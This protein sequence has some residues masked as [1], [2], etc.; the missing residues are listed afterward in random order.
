M[1]AAI[2]SFRPAPDEAAWDL[3]VFRKTRERFCS[4]Q[5]KQH[6][7]SSLRLALSRQEEDG[8]LNC[9]IRA[10]ELECALSDLGS[11]EAQ[12]AAE[13]LDALAAQALHP[14]CTEP[15]RD[16]LAAFSGL[17]LPPFVFVSHVEGFSYYG[18]HPLDFW[19]LAGVLKLRA[20]SAAVIG[21]R[22]IGSTLSSIVRR[23]LHCRGQR[24]ERI[25]VRPTGAP[26]HRRLELTAEQMR[27]V[28][29][30]LR[31]G[32]EFMVVDEGPGFSGS[33]FTA[34]GRALR[35]AGVPNQ[36][37]Q[38]L[39]SRSPESSELQAR[40][41]PEWQS[42]RFCSVVQG[43][44]IP[45]AGKVYC[46]GGYW[47]QTRF[48][49][50]REWPACWTQLERNKYF[51]ADG[52][53]LFKFEGFGRYG[54]SVAE[55]G[56]QLAEAGFAP[57]LLGSDN[58]FVEYAAAPGRPMRA[59]QCRM[60]TLERL[61]DYC[62]FRALNQTAA[63]PGAISLESMLQHNLKVEFGRERWGLKAPV[64]RL[65]V[66]DG[67]MMPH[68]WI[69]ADGQLMK[70]DGA[71]HGDDHL[72]PGATDIA[73][74]LAGAIAEW[75]LGREQ[76]DFFLAEYR[77]RSGDD[78]ASR[79]PFYLLAYSVFRMAYCRMG[80]AAM[81]AW[82]ESHRLKR[83]Y[84]RHRSRVVSLLGLSEDGG[85]GAGLPGAWRAQQAA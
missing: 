10:G 1:R 65:V 21:I 23:A 72:F 12:R 60:K 43:T 28:G 78:A 24:A 64:D 25:T 55:R 15:T 9:L 85:G 42:F 45:A 29:E 62:A 18:L 68:E 75:N 50:E 8:L 16:I 30:H 46:A 70:T 35:Q 82:E 7:L 40:F 61:A 84:L 63:A 13:A 79:L 56:R 52:R 20:A 67:R 38:F 32:S 22:S 39:G 83:E 4:E 26:Y 11:P 76:R 58:G 6:L 27:W 34:V 77:R 3:F 2:E 47:R 36:R 14:E 19:D 31:L 5:L 69:A 73:W 59:E 51:S 81:A 49:E 17:Q 66:A 57:A 41:D 80:A 54:E 33:S 37:I 53:S 71:S 74:D 48:A 44:R